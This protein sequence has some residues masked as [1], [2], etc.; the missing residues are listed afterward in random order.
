MI[1]TLQVTTGILLSMIYFAQTEMSFEVI[2]SI[3]RDNPMG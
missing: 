2:A 1:L 3:M